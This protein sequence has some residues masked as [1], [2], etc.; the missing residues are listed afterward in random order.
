[1]ILA[2]FAACLTAGL[3]G[4]LQQPKFRRGGSSVRLMRRGG[5]LRHRPLRGNPDKL[6]RHA[7]HQRAVDGLLGVSAASQQDRLKCISQN[8]I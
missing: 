4:E 2:V 8:L 1:M 3:F 6:D 7:A 5:A